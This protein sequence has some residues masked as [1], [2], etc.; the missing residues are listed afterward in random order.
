MGSVLGQSHLCGYQEEDVGLKGHHCLLLVLL[1][2]V[3]G[4][5]LSVEV[6]SGLGTLKALVESVSTD[7]PIEVLPAWGW[8]RQMPDLP[9]VLTGACLHSPQH[10]TH[11]LTLAL[12]P[13]L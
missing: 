5:G 4:P 13:R 3:L 1:G 12:P 8:V 10:S 9:L 6:I 7:E 2:R 11:L